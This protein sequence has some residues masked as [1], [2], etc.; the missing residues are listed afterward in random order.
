[1]DNP[2]RCAWALGSPLM[3][4]Y[5]DREWGVPIHDDRQLFELL[6]LEG[7]QAGLSW[8]T[9]LNKREGY[10][11][12]FQGFD[13]EAVAAFGPDDVDALVQS[14]Q[15]VRNRAKIE[16]AIGNAAALLRVVAEEGSFDRY[17]WS[18]VGG[19]PIQNAWS[20]LAGVPAQTTG[21]AAMS[22]AL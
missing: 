7:A 12:A 19:R 20:A 15:I 9:I 3:V 14:P 5:H 16:A 8:S 13:P 21:S 1:M 22:A 4:A 11:Q 10:R 2:P 17:I 18:F 6:V